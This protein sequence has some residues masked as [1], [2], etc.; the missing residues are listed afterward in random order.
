MDPSRPA[1]TLPRLIASRGDSVSSLVAQ[2]PL[3]QEQWFRG[4]G[5]RSGDAPAEEAV[6][7]QGGGAPAECGAEVPRVVAVPTAPTQH[8]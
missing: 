2:D 1:I 7:D 6:P 4:S 3:R 8:A 5:D